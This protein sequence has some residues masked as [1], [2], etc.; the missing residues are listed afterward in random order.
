M[1]T[2]AY[3]R[4]QTVNGASSAL[5]ALVRPQAT[6]FVFDQSRLAESAI[7]SVALLE[8]D[9]RRR[10]FIDDRPPR[11]FMPDVDD[12]PWAKAGQTRLDATAPYGEL[13][14]AMELLALSN[15]RPSGPLEEIQRFVSVGNNLYQYSI[16]GKG[17]LYALLI[18]APLSLQTFS[19][20]IENP[21]GVGAIVFFLDPMPLANWAHPCTFIFVLE[22]KI[23]AVLGNMPPTTPAL[24]L[25]EKR[26]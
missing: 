3:S 14:I 10:Y 22:G 4:S 12:S 15:R 26:K 23:A 7:D 2:A 8:R 13:S 18:H 20:T 19:H 9:R 25:V 21:L 16:S 5:E 17:D 1:Q 11:S 6:G 24:V